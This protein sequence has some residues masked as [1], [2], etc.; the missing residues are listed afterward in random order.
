MGQVQKLGLSRSFPLRAS[1]VGGKLCNPQPPASILQQ[2]EPGSRALGGRR[3]A[4]MTKSLAHLRQARRSSPRRGIFE[5]LWA[6]FRLLCRPSFPQ[7]LR[8][9][10]PQN[11][12]WPRCRAHPI[13]GS[14]GWVLLCPWEPRDGGDRED[15]GNSGDRGFFVL[16][17]HPKKRDEG[18]LKKGKARMRWPGLA[19]AGVLAA[20]HRGPG[21]EG[22]GGGHHDHSG[23]GCI[24]PAQAMA[25]ERET[26]NSVPFK[27]G[28][29]RANLIRD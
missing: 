9:N 1:G 21:T 2:P 12:P 25:L 23:V 27:S 17:R 6:R 16:W 8:K 15:R 26:V 29:M 7:W 14:L 20:S 13:G 4:A 18:S 10:P 5:M 28:I 19:A 24:T 11:S 22:P 3:E